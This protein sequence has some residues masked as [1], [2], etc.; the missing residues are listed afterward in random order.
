[1]GWTKAGPSLRAVGPTGWKL[2]S[3]IFFRRFLAYQ[4]RFPHL[5]LRF[6]TLDSVEKCYWPGTLAI[7]Y[8][9]VRISD[10]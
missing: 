10:C 7:Y 5:V 9:I 6:Y 8:L 2:G 3:D 1:M 4:P